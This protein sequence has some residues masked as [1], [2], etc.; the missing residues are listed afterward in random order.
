MKAAVFT[1]AGQSPRLT[2]LP[3]PV[4]GPDDVLVRVEACGVCHSDL[5]LVDGDWADSL[6]RCVQP[7]IF[8]HEIVGIVIARGSSVRAVKKGDRVGVGWVG[9]TCGRCEYCIEGNDNLCLERK[10]TGIDRQGGWAGTVSLSAAQSIRVPDEI[11][12]GEAAPLFCAGV[13]VYRGMK[14][15]SI[16]SGQRVAVFGVGGLGHIAVQ[17]AKYWRAETSAVDPSAERLDLARELGARHMLHPGGAAKALLAQG[18]AHVAIVTAASTAAYGEAL[19]S[20]RKGGTLVIVGLPND[21][22]KVIAD[23]LAT[24]EIR[25]VGSAVGSREDQRELLQLAAKGKVRCVVERLALDQVGEALERLREGQV[26][27]RIVLEPR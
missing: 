2:D 25:L 21:P 4:P 1:E 11:D 19:R 17:L 24:R 26:R 15:A 6:S 7:T 20:L 27:G 18:G 12:P 9:Q 5:H 13:T 22:L 14:K 16:R 23:D 8:G 10:I 3:D